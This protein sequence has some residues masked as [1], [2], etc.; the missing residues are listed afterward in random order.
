MKVAFAGESGSYAELAA[1][2]YFG[3]NAKLVS[4]KEFSD[5]FNAVANDQCKYGI[6]PIEN[7]MA[8][9]I[10]QNYDLLLER[11]LHIS[12]E[13]YL[14][15]GHFLIGNKNSKIKDITHAYSHPQALTQC[16]NYL[17]KKGIIPVPCSNTAYAVKKVRDDKLFNA[18]A[19]SSMKA[20]ADFDMKILDSNI[21]D[22]EWN[23]TRFLILSKNL[24]KLRRSNEPRKTSI[25][26][27]TKN[28]PGALF[29]CLAVFALRDID[30]FKIE[31]R[32]VNGKGFEY[33][34]YLD[35]SGDLQSEDR[36][37]AI[38]HLQEITTFYRNMGSYPVGRHVN[39][40]CN[41]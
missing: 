28:I 41:P 22:N 39:P 11:N 35:F 8:G 12:G 30:L 23:T 25:V 29:K 34:F 20:A 33:I 38:S 21:E 19:I 26:F 9:S 17:K 6:I 4:V 7:S 37:N 40:E 24:K 32:P 5:V 3:Q 16:K 15:V 31:S 10:H 27:S 18:A 2:E 1:R 14:R 13:I 36:K